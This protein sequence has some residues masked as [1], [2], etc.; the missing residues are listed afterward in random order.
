MIDLKKEVKE[1]LGFMFEAFGD[2]SRR[3]FARFNPQTKRELD[4][5]YKF[6][7]TL[8]RENVKH[9][10]PEEIEDWGGWV[11]D[12]GGGAGNVSVYFAQ[13]GQPVDY[14]DPNYVQQ[15]F[16]KWLKDKYG[17][18]TL[19]VVDVANGKYDCI[20]LRDVV[21]HI[22]DYPS[23]LKP[24]FDLLVLGGLV[25]S[26][27]EFSTPRK[28]GQYFH[29]HDRYGYEDFMASCGLEQIEKYVWRK[30]K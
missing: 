10:V 4:M 24:L 1:Y 25:Y 26:K 5:F 19:N 12:F 14:I 17:L 30:K 28:P 27:P 20:V 18:E 16:M 15:E 29:F 8:L 21:E 3:E 2:D 7:T 13:R 6:S 11:L 23:A 22:E 9:P